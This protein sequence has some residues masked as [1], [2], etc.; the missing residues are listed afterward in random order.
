MKRHLVVIATAVGSAMLLALSACVAL[1]DKR[2][3]LVIGNSTYQRV[4][5]L[6][7][8]VRDATAVAKMFKDA[9][10]DRVELLLDLGNLDFKRA[11][12][13]FEDDIV[14]GADIAVIYFAGHGF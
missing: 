6:P 12:Y 14:P 2:V 10:F 13:R 4:A 1:A 7:N 5:K 3:A 9:G 8:P 11:I